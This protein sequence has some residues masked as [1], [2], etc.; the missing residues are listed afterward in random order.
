MRE[1]ASKL[2]LRPVSLLRVL[3]A[4]M[5]PSY[6]GCSL[7]SEAQKTEQHL[8][9][10]FATDQSIPFILGDTKH[11]LMHTLQRRKRSIPLRLI[12]YRIRS[13]IAPDVYTFDLYS[14]SGLGSVCMQFAALLPFRCQALLAGSFSGVFSLH[15]TPSQNLLCRTSGP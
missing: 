9:Q 2:K 4:A 1:V 7:R 14:S 6:I 11:T 8:H 12:I 5:V 3:I 15:H 13:Y 10:F